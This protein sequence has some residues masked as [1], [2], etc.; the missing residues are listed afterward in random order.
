MDVVVD[1]SV[2]IA[3]ITNEASKPELI[4]ATRDAA[5]IAP[6][7]VH[8]EIGNAFSAML[9]RKRV[10]LEQVARALTHYHDIPIR[11]VEVDLHA[12]LT[13]AEQLD[14]YAYDAYLIH[15]AER[16]RG[17][18]LTLDLALRNHASSYGVPLLEVPR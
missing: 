15:C 5:L 9:K 12:S 1:T 4:R 10:T 14:L 6:V 8:F 17:P 11:F 2:I 16:Y 13:I 7:S 18:L 3:I